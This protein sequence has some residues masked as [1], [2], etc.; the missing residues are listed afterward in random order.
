MSME[1][2]IFLVGGFLVVLEKIKYD[3][4]EMIK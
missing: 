2:D 4:L 1:N 3:K